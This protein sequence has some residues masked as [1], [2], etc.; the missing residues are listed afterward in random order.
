M[1]SK[2][3]FIGNWKMNGLKKDLVQLK[4]VDSFLKRNIFLRKSI[5]SIFCLPNTLIDFYRT[6]LSKEIK[7]GSQN[8]SNVNVSFGANTG[9]VSFSM[10]KD[11]KCEYVL[12]GHSELR[13]AGENDKSI[14]N[15][16][17]NSKQSKLKIVLCVG[18]S[19]KDFKSGKAYKKVTNQ[20]LL[21]LKNNKKL[22]NKII[23]AYEPIW[24]I[25]TGIVPKTIYL[26]NFFDKL[27]FFLIK[28]FK[29]KIPIIYGG[30]VSS[31]NIKEFKNIK[32][33]NG[34]LIG[35][36]SLKSKNYIDIIKNYYN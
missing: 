6:N 26:K 13:S 1:Y 27:N 14:S 11:L 21:A 7:I 19:L 12:V 10:L 17:K 31:K 15:K 2:K 3:Y 23:I 34:F 24:S 9:F 20:I 16:I 4:K 25:G 8:V 30:S 18:D 5:I 36:A 22:L 29:K 32:K 35:G 33:C 28:K